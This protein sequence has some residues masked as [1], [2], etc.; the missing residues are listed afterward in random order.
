MSVEDPFFV[1]KGE[2]E[3]A[4]AKCRVLRQSWQ[5]ILN[6]V[7]VSKRDDYDR[8]SN[9]LRNSIRSIEWD[10]EDLDETIGIVEMNPQKFY[11]TPEELETRK[12]F[13]KQ[14]RVSVQAIVNEL[15]DPATKVKADKIFRKSLMENGLNTTHY[16]HNHHHHNNKTSSRNRL[17]EDEQHENAAFIDD[18][19]QR[20]QMIMRDQ[21][22]QLD[23]VADSVGVLKHMSQSIGNE[24]DEQAVIL[25]DLGNDIENTQNKMD[26]VLRKMAKVTHMSNDRRQ[27][28][29]I[30]VLGSSM[31]AIFILF[32]IFWKS[33]SPSS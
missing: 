25:N 32:I 24:L 27:W 1:V 5:D 3:N 9:E 18:Q 26:A 6:D 4:V 20:Q 15:N 11:I 14:T 30:G 22:V 13:I 29:A 31:F 12:D 16:N 17:K 23:M 21:D 19:Q 7:T 8:I 10:L 33:S 28:C 2:V